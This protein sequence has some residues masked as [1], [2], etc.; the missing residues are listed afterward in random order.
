MSQQVAERP[1]AVTP[2]PMRHWARALLIVICALIGVMWVYALV[3]APKKAVYR[4]D[5]DA[6]RAHAE[7]RCTTARTERLALA[8]TEGGYIAEPTAAQMIE[9]AG[10]VDQATD[11]VEAMLD[12]VVAEPVLTERDREI[13]GRFETQY[14][15]LID[16][17][18]A[19]TTLLREGVD[20][21]YHETRVAG[22]P[23][24]NVLVDFVT[25][26]EIKSCAPPGE[27]GGDA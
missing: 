14:R 6:W 2:P 5:D 13:V 23:V 7:A 11:V 15:I 21:P 9:R 12:D 24:T 4:V 1:A 26:N 25:V 16:D 27:L 10:I 18:R 3:F 22:G 8:D 20:Q 19:Y 17:R